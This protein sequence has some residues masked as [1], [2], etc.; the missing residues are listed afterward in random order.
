MT[1]LQETFSNWYDSLPCGEPSYQETFEAGMRAA[2]AQPVAQPLELTTEEVEKCWEQTSG[3]T[4][5]YGPFARA[6][7]I[8]ANKKAGL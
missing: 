8:A 5:G 6:I 7:L 4:F 1:T 3:T 2:L